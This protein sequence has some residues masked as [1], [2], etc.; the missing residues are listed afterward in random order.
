MGSPDVQRMYLHRSLKKHHQKLWALL[1]M[2]CQY[3]SIIA[4]HSVE[5]VQFDSLLFNKLLLEAR[6]PPSISSIITSVWR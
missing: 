6:I 5:L 4:S 2:S 1:H 3:S